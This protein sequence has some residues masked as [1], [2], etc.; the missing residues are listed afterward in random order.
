MAIS[1][2]VQRTS[3]WPS[4]HDRY[5]RPL[6]ISCRISRLWARAGCV[7]SIALYFST[8]W[9]RW[10]SGIIGRRSGFPESPFGRTRSTHRS[11][12]TVA[13]PV[14]NFLNQ[15]HLRIRL[16]WFEERPA[17]LSATSRPLRHFSALQLI[18]LH[19]VILHRRTSPG[20]RRRPVS[21]RPSP[22]RCPCWHLASYCWSHGGQEEFHIRRAL[23]R[24]APLGGAI[25]RSGRICD[26]SN[27][28]GWK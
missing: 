20:S 7:A 4:H 14:G 17:R 24:A 12:R 25:N 21:R 16:V 28:R 22:V 6:R 8:L 27:D 5:V 10:T 1:C 3:R 15:V 11:S 19:L 13:T 23:G 9:N 2:G 26:C 18:H